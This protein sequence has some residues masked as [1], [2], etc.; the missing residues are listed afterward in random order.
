VVR[1][2]LTGDLLDAGVDRA[3]VAATNQELA[4]HP[5][6]D[7]FW[8]HRRIAHKR[9]WLLL[10]YIDDLITD[11]QHRG[12]SVVVFV[13]ND[14][15]TDCL[16]RPEPGDRYEQR[17]RSILVYVDIPDEPANPDM[18]A[19]P[20]AVYYPLWRAIDDITHAIEIWRCKDRIRL[21]DLPPWM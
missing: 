7:H 3:V 19:G 1:L 9:W 16:Q 18:Y 13:D 10:P 12:Q 6:P 2:K 17:D 8:D 21:Q 4:T 5:Q 15:V 11:L 20:I 14:I